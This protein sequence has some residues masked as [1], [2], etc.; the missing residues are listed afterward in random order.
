MRYFVITLLRYYVIALLR[1]YV[2]AFTLLRYFDS[3]LVAP[4]S[5]SA[6]GVF[7]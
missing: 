6:A 7:L 3:L 2:I 1:Y 4:V 5:A